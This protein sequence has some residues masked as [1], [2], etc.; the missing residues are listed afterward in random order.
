MASVDII[1]LARAEDCNSVEGPTVLGGR[2]MGDGDGTKKYE[3]FFVRQLRIEVC[4]GALN[5]G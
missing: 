3:F 2:G 4:K 5:S 1:G